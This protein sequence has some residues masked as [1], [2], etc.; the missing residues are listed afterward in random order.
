MIKQQGDGK[1]SSRPH[2][3]PQDGQQDST[4]AAGEEGCLLRGKYQDFRNEQNDNLL[5]NF[6]LYFLKDFHLH[7]ALRDIS[8]SCGKEAAKKHFLHCPVRKDNCLL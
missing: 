6:M 4:P 1:G 7:H 5:Q 8:K 2:N 3:P